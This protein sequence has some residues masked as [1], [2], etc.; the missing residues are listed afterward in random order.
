MKSASVVNVILF[1]ALM[2]LGYLAALYLDSTKPSYVMEQSSPRKP[3]LGQQVP[4]F[5]FTDMA[6]NTHKISDFRGK[7][8]IL[9]F[10]ASWCAPC[11]KEFPVLLRAA[12][13]SPER[14]ALIAL[15]SD[16]EDGAIKTFLA[17]KAAGWKRANV[18]IARDAEDVTQKLFQTYMLPET[19]I[20]DPDGRI[21]EKFIGADWEPESLDRAIS[22]SL[23]NKESQK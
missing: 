20:I 6:G 14:T 9:N 2:L 13:K 7:A 12:Q 16:M 5:P 3:A 4:D 22:E 11:V 8:V 10:W 18:F 19:F 21:R 17:R 1:A 15:S 23:K